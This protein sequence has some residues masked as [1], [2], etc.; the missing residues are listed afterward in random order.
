MA[1]LLLRH[2]DVAG[3]LTAVAVLGGTVGFACWPVAGRTGEEWLPTVSR[4]GAAAATG[5]RHRR[6]LASWGGHE[7]RLDAAEAPRLR[8]V[9]MRGPF[10]GLSLLGVGPGGGDEGVAGVGMLHDARE[11]TCTA[12]VPLRGH[13]FGLLGTDEKGRRVDGWAGALASLSRERSVVHRVQWVA[14]TAPDDGRAVR[15]HFEERATCSAESGAWASYADLVRR[16]TPDTSQHLVYLAVQVR[17][18]RGRSPSPAIRARDR[19]GPHRANGAA[20]MARPAAELLRE[21]GNLRRLLAEADVLA[22]PP[23][24][25]EALAAVIRQSCDERPNPD[26]AAEGGAEREAGTSW[27]WPIATRVHWDCLQT[28]ATW[29][30]TYWIAEWPRVEV[31]PD[32]LAPLL[33]GPVR[34]TVSIVMEPVSPSRASRQVERARTADV[35][36]SE[37]RRRGGFLST[38]RRSREAELVERREAELADGHASFRF[39]GYVT[40]TAPTHEQ[41][42]EACASTEQAGGQ[43]RCELRRLFGDQERGFTSALPLCRGLA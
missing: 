34:R 26:A 31:G 20:R 30:A 7:G 22:G 24:T 13:S 2:P 18:G 9:R 25:P 27:P 11:C 5:A 43:A 39:S 23:L 38:A 14:M 17:T 6:G 19:A 12:V 1:I 8:A 33:L 36:D 42:A 15:G 4:W 35:A 41:L 10:A 3:I 16:T 37:L 32:F 28:D 40:V 21:V 29:Q